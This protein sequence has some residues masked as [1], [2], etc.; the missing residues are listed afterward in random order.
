MGSVFL[1]KNIKLKEKDR[2]STKCFSFNVDEEYKELR[3]FLSFSPGVLEDEE[4]C[5]SKIQREIK[6]YLDSEDE[7][8]SFKQFI[9]LK[10][11]VT[12]SLQHEGEYLGNAHRWNMN[13]KH[14]ISTEI[15]SPGFN[16]CKCTKGEWKV[17]MHIHEIVTEKC[18]VNLVVKGEL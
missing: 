14:I 2:K 9:P 13:Q 6:N 3:V 10:N 12:L 16:L 18:A 7:V 4:K 15:A 1:E 11:L 5:K 8:P 17:I